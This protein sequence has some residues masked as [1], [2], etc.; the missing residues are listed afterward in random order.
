[1][2][3]RINNLQTV[4][5]KSSIYDEGFNQ[6]EVMAE[7]FAAFNDRK[8]IYRNK[9]LVLKTTNSRAAEAQKLLE[10][11]NPEIVE[12]GHVGLY[13]QSENSKSFRSEWET[14]GISYKK[15]KKELLR[16]ME[17]V[18]ER[19]LARLNDTRSTVNGVLTLEGNGYNKFYITYEIQ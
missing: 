19:H 2:K 1:M 10:Y 14:S 4:T 9:Q 5:A 17:Q 3:V 16:F 13:A 11:H 18:V 15:F 7:L 6:A 8:F 12:D